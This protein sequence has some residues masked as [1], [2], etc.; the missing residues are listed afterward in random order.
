[1][2]MWPQ[3]GTL[4]GAKVNDAMDL[5]LNFSTMY[6]WY[7]DLDPGDNFTFATLHTDFE[8]D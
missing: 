8:R 6:L 4:A 2:I 5:Y 1:M 7:G 3:N